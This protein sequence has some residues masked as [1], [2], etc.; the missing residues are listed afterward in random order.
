MFY[1]EK[2]DTTAWGKLYHRSL[3][4]SSIRYP[5][6]LLFEDLPTT[7]LL[8][9]QCDKIAFKAVELYYYLLR[10]DSIEV[11]SLVQRRWIAR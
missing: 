9:K 1:Q 4:E 10:S 5:K 11:Q 2:F 3:F 6:G 7:Y 8:F